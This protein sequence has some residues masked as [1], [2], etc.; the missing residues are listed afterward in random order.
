MLALSRLSFK[1]YYGKNYFAR[2]SYPIIR[3][4]AFENYNDLWIYTYVILLSTLAVGEE[5]FKMDKCVETSCYY[6]T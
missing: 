6:K 2:T 5:C 3:L 1:F 4:P